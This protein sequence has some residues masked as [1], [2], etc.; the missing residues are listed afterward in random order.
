MIPPANGSLSLFGHA[1]LAG[2]AAA[3]AVL[4]GCAT[5]E[6]PLPPSGGHTTCLEDTPECIG[7]RQG[8]MRQL[9]ND[10]GRGWMKEPATPEAYASGVRLYAMKTKKKDLSCEE[11]MRGRIEADGAATSL[12]GASA[13]LTPAQVSRGIMFAGEVSRELQTEMGRRCKRA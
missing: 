11:L 6:A 13:R 3:A 8:L 9:A 4:T 5:A 7:R 10:P 2:L 1:A 12:R